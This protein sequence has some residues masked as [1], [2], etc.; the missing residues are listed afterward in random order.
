MVM[1]ELFRSLMKVN[2]NT[3]LQQNL[4]TTTYRLT[5]DMQS[6]QKHMIIKCKTSAN[7]VQKIKSVVLLLKK[8]ML[9]V[10]LVKFKLI[11]R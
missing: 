3:R 6:T 2:I 10:L 4:N 8:N 5:S 7:G 1:I 11:W 9:Q